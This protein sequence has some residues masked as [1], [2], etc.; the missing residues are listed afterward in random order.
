MKKFV[1][2]SVGAAA[3]VL[4][5]LYAV[6]VRG[7]YVDFDRGAAVRAEYLAR[8][9]EIYRAGSGD[10]L[11]IRGVDVS[12]S[13][14]GHYLGEYAAT[15]EDYLRWLHLIGEMGAN[16]VRVYTIM[17][18]DFYNALYEYNSV[19]QTPLFLVQ[20][21]RVSEAANYG[22]E[23]AAGDQFLG[24]LLEH[25][26]RAVDIVHGNAVAVLNDATGSGAYF[27]DISE[28]VIGYQIGDEWSPE[29]VVYTDHSSALTPGY[30]GEYF[31]VSADATNFESI[32]A[33]V[34]DTLT[35]YEAD[36]Y[37]CQRLVGILC[38]PTTDF[39]EYDDE[40][41]QI[42]GKF[43]HINPEHILAGARLTS[44]F[45]VS[46]KLF[47][48]CDDFTLYL[49]EAQKTVLADILQD[50]DRSALY[51]GYPALLRRY[52]TMPILAGFQYSTARGI[53]RMDEPALTERQQG[54]KLMQLYEEV[55]SSGWSGG[56]ISAWQDA[57]EQ[58]AWNT[59]FAS[60]LSQNSMW[61]DLQTA[62]QSCGIMAFVPGGEEAVCLVDGDASEWSQQD[63]VLEQD[64][65]AVSLR[66]DAE[67]IYLLIRGSAL[68][69]RR[70]YLPIDT[71]H[72]AGAAFYTDESGDTVS[73]D[74]GADFLVCVN[75]MQD[76]RLLVHEVSDAA[77]VN[78]LEEVNGRNP[79]VD[80]PAADSS[81]FYESRMA[82]EKRL[83]MELRIAL[84]AQIAAGMAPQDI[85][86]IYSL[87]FFD[88]GR[89]VHGNGNPQS[90][91]YN[92]LADFCFGEDLVELRL[93]WMLLNF[94]N[95]SEMQVHDDY[96]A[97]YGVQSRQIRQ[98][99][100]G[101]G[102]AGS[103]VSLQPVLLK[104]WGTKVPCHE[105]LKESYYVIQDKW[106]ETNGAVSR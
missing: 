101:A 18:D 31:A 47:R 103:A 54:E 106:K 64:G 73:F 46:Y 69:D 72:N 81:V 24:Q 93:P 60:E 83:D 28:W 50:V 74:R 40:Y 67:G 10:A 102:E 27:R 14:P 85:S 34:M 88:T 100:I 99:W 104:G 44:G 75:G 53:Q 65:L 37:K 68:A 96:Y 23:N 16:T 76:S 84:R 25:A 33:Q 71:Q 49:S 86:G 32:L 13:V 48:Y 1:L 92:S 17:D 26:K 43:C 78:F 56:F 97:H 19:S 80:T 98:I 57:W 29:T 55:V 38:D 66:Y 61:H 45:F 87:E 12:A 59:A 63:L 82:V 52:H 15:Q 3:L 8:G 36:K 62:G 4:G 89:L 6:F 39:L 21:I 91:A 58:R 22:V 30:Q 42:L 9:T 35:G 95:P 11:C 94:S 79:F 5:I 41:A 77:R 90:A 51:D 7:F 105:R 70:I 20:G 2:C